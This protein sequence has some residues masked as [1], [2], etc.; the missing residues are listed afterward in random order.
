MARKKEKV[1]AFDV[2]QPDT[3]HP[4]TDRICRNFVCYDSKVK[5][6][7]VS[8][9]RKENWKH[10]IKIQKDFDIL[11]GYQTELRGGLG[12]IGSDFVSLV[13]VTLEKTVKTTTPYIYRVTDYTL[14]R[15]TET[16]GTKKDAIQYIQKKIKTKNVVIHY[17]GKTERCEMDPQHIDDILGTLEED[18]IDF[19]IAQVGRGDVEGDIILITIY[20]NLLKV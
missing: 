10:D 3:L 1:M 16:F 12:N 5:E 4:A 8:E 6:C 13:P 9:D 20:K 11:L 17:D 2:M 19:D 15:A 18:T 14:P 7:L